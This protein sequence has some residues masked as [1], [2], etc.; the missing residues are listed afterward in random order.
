MMHS[1]LKQVPVSNGDS[2]PNF[3]R[4]TELWNEVQGTKILLEHY[5][6][7]W[8]PILKEA[9]PFVNNNNTVKTPNLFF[10]AIYFAF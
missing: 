5:L 9:S 3:V 1:N 10:K 2:R 8:Y 4:S 6:S 7:I